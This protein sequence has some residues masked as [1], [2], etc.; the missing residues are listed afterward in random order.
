[1]HK[2]STAVPKSS[3]VR[4][5][6][7]VRPTSGYPLVGLLNVLQGVRLRGPTIARG[8]THSGRALSSLRDENLC[9]IRA[10]KGHDFSV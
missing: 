9:I 1:M 7:T 2:F 5:A 10:R 6:P 8:A 4:C 3:G